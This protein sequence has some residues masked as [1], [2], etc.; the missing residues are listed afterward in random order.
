MKKIAAI[1]ARLS[2]EDEDK[3]DGKESKSIESQI[4]TLSD[5]ANEHDIEIY[6]IYYDDGYSGSTQNVL[7]P[8]SWTDRILN[9]FYKIVMLTSLTYY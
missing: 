1:Y 4:K 5:Y 9:A 7:N 3:I 8:K 6:K 2:R